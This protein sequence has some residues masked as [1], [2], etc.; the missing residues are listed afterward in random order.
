MS[1]ESSHKLRIF[2]EYTESGHE[3][4]NWM[5]KYK[6][7]C[8]CNHLHSTHSY[9]QL[10]VFFQTIYKNHIIWIISFRW[11]FE[12]STNIKWCN[13]QSTEFRYI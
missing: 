1:D 5:V 7:Q 8:Y 3:T 12:Q 6:T 4:W 10:T 11:C 2:D 13:M 9:I